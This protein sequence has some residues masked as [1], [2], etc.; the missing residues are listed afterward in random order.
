MNFSIEYDNQPLNFLKKQDKHIIKRILDKIDE[1]L[2]NNA[3]PHNA[4]TMAGEHGI[5]RIRIGDYRAPYRINY[6]ENKI[7]V[8]KLDKRSKVDKE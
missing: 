8:F 3:V 2:T 5:Y 1:L 6:Q 7:I 4:K